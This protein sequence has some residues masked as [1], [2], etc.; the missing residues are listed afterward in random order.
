MNHPLDGVLLVCV[1]R[2]VLRIL[3]IHITHH[4]AILVF[5]INHSECV[6]HLKYVQC[7]DRINIFLFSFFCEISISLDKIRQIDGQKLYV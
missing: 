5:L 7:I 2:N 6:E 3:G 1:W 4:S